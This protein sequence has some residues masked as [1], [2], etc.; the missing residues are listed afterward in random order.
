MLSGDEYKN[1]LGISWQK[2]NF[3]ST[4]WEI[5]TGGFDFG[6]DSVLVGEHLG[7]NPF[8]VFEFFV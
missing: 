8:C 1:R 4:E 7:K 6:I 2:S 3:F 5:Q